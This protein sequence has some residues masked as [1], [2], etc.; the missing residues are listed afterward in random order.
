MLGTQCREHKTMTNRI[1]LR[2]FLGLALALT[3]PA[4][5][6]VGQTEPNARFWNAGPPSYR[7]VDVVTNRLLDP[8]QTPIGAF[9]NRAYLYV[10]LAIYDATIAA[11]DSKYA[12]NRKRPSEL[13]PA[14]TPRVAVPRSPSYPSDYAATAFAAADVLAYLNPGEAATFRGMAEEA[15]RSRLFAGVELPS[16][17]SA[18]V[19]LGHRVAERVIAMAKADGSDVAWTGSV[20]SEP[21]KWTGTNPGNVTMPGWRPM[22]L[23]S[24]SE[25][26]PAP[27]PACDSAE[28]QAEMANVRNFPRALTTAN[29]LTNA[30]AFFWQ[31]P[32]S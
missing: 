12:Y 5:D 30:K 21:C 26:R 28:G 10:S 14:I 20:P 27:P 6:G 19:D 9:P 15:A 13:D 31:L 2:T 29:F 4:Q 8:T 23:A 25:F 11:W 1:T 24:T 22:L 16:D 3:A 18:G 7:W 17:Y 32:P